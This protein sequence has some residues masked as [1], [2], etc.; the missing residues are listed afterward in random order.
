MSPSLGAL[1][2]TKKIEEKKQ[3]ISEPLC[4]SK[5]HETLQKRLPTGVQKGEGIS[6]VAPLGAACGSLGAPIEFLMQK[7]LPK[8]SKNEDPMAKVTPKDTPWT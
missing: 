5:K 3:P 1:R 2:V 8:S 7:V 6:G 4:F